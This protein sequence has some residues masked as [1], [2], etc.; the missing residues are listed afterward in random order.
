MSGK[1]PEPA[2][3][4]SKPKAKAKKVVVLIN[5]F[6]DEHLESLPDWFMK[7]TSMGEANTMKEVIGSKQMHIVKNYPAPPNLLECIGHTCFVL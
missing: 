1:H 2:K 7:M 3:S 5:Y 4:P 6:L